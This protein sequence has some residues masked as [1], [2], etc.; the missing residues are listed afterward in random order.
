MVPPY[1]AEDLAEGEDPKIT[2]LK[3]LAFRKLKSGLAGKIF[4]L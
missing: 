2:T 4:V 3:R 1:E